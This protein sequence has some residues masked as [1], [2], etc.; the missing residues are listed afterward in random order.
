M[1]R[2]EEDQREAVVGLTPR[3]VAVPEA[4]RPAWGACQTRIEARIGAASLDFFPKTLK[5]LQFFA[6]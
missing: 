5:E 6:A 4:A 3:G 1:G 2:G